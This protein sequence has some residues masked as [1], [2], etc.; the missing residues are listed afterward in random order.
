MDSLVYCDDIYV[1][2]HDEEIGADEC[3]LQ[4][5]FGATSK[6]GIASQAQSL[7]SDNDKSG[8]S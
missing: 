4:R 3:V 7:A 8:S 2:L 1:G 6:G 5:A